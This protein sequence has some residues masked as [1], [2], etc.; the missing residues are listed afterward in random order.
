MNSIWKI[1]MWLFLAHKKFRNSK[2][3]VYSN[4]TIPQ[5]KNVKW[6][7][8]STLHKENKLSFSEKKVEDSSFYH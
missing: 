3:E 6:R 5:L 7:K 8:K 2:I 4:C 1:N